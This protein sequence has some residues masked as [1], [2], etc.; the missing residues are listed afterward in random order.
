MQGFSSA[1]IV[2]QCTTQ[3]SITERQGYKY[4]KQAYRLFRAQVEKDVDTQKELHVQ[5][6]LKLYR[7]LKDKSL[8]KSAGV[9]LSILQDIAKL[10]GLY[11]EKIDHTNAGKPFQYDTKHEVVFINF[12]DAQV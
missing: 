8:G 7:E 9:A 11:V 3:W 5:S 1:D 2:R 10:Q 4:I 6:R 12:S